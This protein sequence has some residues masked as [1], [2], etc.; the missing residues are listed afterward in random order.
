MLPSDKHLVRLASQL[1][2]ESCKKIVLRLGLQDI[3][4]KNLSHAYSHDALTLNNVIYLD[5]YKDKRTINKE[6]V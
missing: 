2:I 1:D 3:Y 6:I 4:W 5:E